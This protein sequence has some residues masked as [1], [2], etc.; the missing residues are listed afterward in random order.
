MKKENKTKTKTK[1]GENIVTPNLKIC[2]KA[3][4]IKNA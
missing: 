4:I 1:K 3:I 2:Y